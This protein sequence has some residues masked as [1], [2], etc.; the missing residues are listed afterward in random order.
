M[1]TEKEIRIPYSEY[2]NMVDI[3]NTQSKTLQEIAELKTDDKVVILTDSYSIRNGYEYHTYTYKDSIP[4]DREILNLQVFDIDTN[5]QGRWEE[6]SYNYKKG[7]EI[8]L[9]VIGE[10][11]D[12]RREIGLLQDKLENAKNLI[13]WWKDKSFI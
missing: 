4:L 3:I 2:Q 8:F 5:V 10:L 12:C 6:L 11:K 7:K 13:P 1:I 9:K